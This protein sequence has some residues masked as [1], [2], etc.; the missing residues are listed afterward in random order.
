MVAAVLYIEMLFKKRSVLLLS[1]R[2][3]QV[4]DLRPW[5]WVMGMF[6]KNFSYWKID[7]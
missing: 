7:V 1:I 2:G 5:Y 4:Q 6:S 3:K